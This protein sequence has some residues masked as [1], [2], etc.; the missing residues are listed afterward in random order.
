[1]NY[2]DLQKIRHHQKL[3]L[4]FIVDVEDNGLKVPPLLFIILVENAFKH[5]IEPTDQDSYLS[6]S[7]K[8]MN[9]VIDFVCENS[10]PNIYTKSEDGV[11]L[12]NLKKRLKLTYG[13]D[14]SLKYNTLKNKFLANLQIKSGKENSFE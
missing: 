11:G 9:G 2:L 13:E 5:G 4:S 7:I 8:E 14:Y 12:T 1:M 6:I 3:D 10:L